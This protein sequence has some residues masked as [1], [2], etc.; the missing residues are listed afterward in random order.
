M[1]AKGKWDISLFSC[2]NEE[3]ATH[4]R[5]HENV[6]LTGVKFHKLWVGISASVVLQSFCLAVKEPML[7]PN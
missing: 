4:L 5:Q 6:R 1:F 7:S 2:H 3:A